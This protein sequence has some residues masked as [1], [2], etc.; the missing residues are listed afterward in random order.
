M[1]ATTRDGRDLATFENYGD[2]TGAQHVIVDANAI[3]TVTA[4]TVA[5]STTS[6]TALAANTNRKNATFVNNGAADVTIRRGAGPAAAGAGIVLKANGGAY[7]I[8][9]RNLYK[10][11]V[12]CITASG[13]SSL[14]I[15]EGV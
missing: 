12:T 7:E 10:G 11:V 5:V 8:D 15:E 3:T 14:A 13:T 9:S 1:A 6:S 2:G 4:A